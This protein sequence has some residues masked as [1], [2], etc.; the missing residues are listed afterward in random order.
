MELLIVLLIAGV[1][2]YF[3]AR[4]RFSKPVDDAAGKVASTSKDY[5]SQASGWARGKFG[6]RSKGE[7]FRAWAAGPGA[8]HLPEDFKTW[9]TGLT[10]A[11]A[12]E[13]TKSL[14][15]YAS[16]LGYDLGKLV[17]GSLDA[18]PAR[19]QTYVEAVVV[20]SQAYRKAREARQ[21]AEKASAS[22]EEPAA[23]VD[24]KTPAKKSVSRRHSDSTEATETAPAA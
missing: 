7:Q 23:P 9:L 16:G 20:Y 1:V 14:D 15:G 13:F 2:G 5:A 12:D 18:Q 11:E 17:D 10:P 8:T 22:K 3:F 19:M 21:E 6:G 24:G 4:S